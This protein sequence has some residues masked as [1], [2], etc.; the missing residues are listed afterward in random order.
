MSLRVFDLFLLENLFIFNFHL[1]YSNSCDRKIKKID[2]C[3][4][5]A[6][7]VIKK[8]G[9][10]KNNEYWCYGKYVIFLRVYES[11]FTVSDSNVG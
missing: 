6:Y 4:W 3:E 5:N 7:D 1:I 11:N 10:K 2:E 8:R 9:R